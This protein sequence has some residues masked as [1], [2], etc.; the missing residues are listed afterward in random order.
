[1]FFNVNN[2]SHDPTGPS[3][4]K[5]MEFAGNSTK[6][7]WG[8]DGIFPPWTDGSHVNG[9]CMHPNKKLIAT[10]WD[11]GFVNLYRF[12]VFKGNK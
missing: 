1:M 6:L 4:C 10:G 5:D 9:V 12:P 2:K 11:W 7:G 8:L 3:N